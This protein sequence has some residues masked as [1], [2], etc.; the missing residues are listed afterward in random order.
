MFETL[1]AA[2]ADLPELSFAAGADVIVEGENRGQLFVLVSGS[3]EVSRDD[4]RVAVVD[5]PGAVFG[6]M[7]VLL[8]TPATA[9]VRSLGGCVLRVSDA[10]EEFLRARPDVARAIAQMLARR[11]DG[12]TRY[13][14]DIREQY[15]DRDDHL[16]VVDVVLESLSHHQAAP[17]E[18]GS[19][20]EDEAPY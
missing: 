11:L 8:N 7:A 17:P 15:A 19:D 14:V 9:T 13:L 4:V 1:L 3:V 6:E 2:A 10:P 12:V 16:G 20:R 18:P 5:E